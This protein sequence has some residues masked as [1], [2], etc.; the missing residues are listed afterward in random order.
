MT[1]FPCHCEALA[2]SVPL[3]KWNFR[4]ANSTQKREMTQA[5]TSTHASTTE[6][7]QTPSSSNNPIRPTNIR[8]APDTLIT[9]ASRI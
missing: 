4:F 5:H 7:Q 3:Q 1:A 8:Y 6:L 2:F 9:L